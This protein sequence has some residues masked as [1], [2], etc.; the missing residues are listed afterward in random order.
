[1]TPSVVILALVTAQRL[2]E[3][4]IANRNTRRLKARGALEYGAWH[5]PL[6]VLFHAGWL[7][8]LWWLAPARD[9]N[10]PLLVVFL[11]LQALRGWVM[12]TLAERWTTRIIVLA[13][14][15][16]VRSGP[17]KYFSHPNYLVVIAEI[18]VLPLIFGL[19]GYAL[20]ASLLNGLIL[21][22]RIREE[23]RALAATRSLS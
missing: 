22:V 15:P 13:G 18:A 9:V 17:Y 16:L 4:A 3:L 6:I 20:I 1:M 8:G 12:A 21:F 2:I 5:Y 11:I 7:A 14:A 10:W 23:E 19:Y